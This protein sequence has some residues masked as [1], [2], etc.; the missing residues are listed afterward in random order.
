MLQMPSHQQREHGGGHRDH[1]PKSS[2]RGGP[3]GRGTS[4]SSRHRRDH[5]EVSC[6]LKYV[7]FGFNVVFWVSVD[8]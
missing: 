7:I 3:G 1:R 4:R 8:S 2:S 6:C 5:S